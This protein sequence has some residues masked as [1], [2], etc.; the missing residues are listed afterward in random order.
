MNT[1]TQPEKAI[2][3]LLNSEKIADRLT[4]SLT[5]YEL[6]KMTLAEINGKYSDR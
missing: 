5:A 4:A 6:F 1:A 2:E 3:S